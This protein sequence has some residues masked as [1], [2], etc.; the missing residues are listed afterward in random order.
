MSRDFFMKEADTVSGNNW[1]RRGQSCP[2]GRARP[3]YER[4]R[5]QM[6]RSC[7]KDSP[8]S[9]FLPV[10][11]RRHRAK[12]DAPRSEKKTKLDM[13]TPAKPT[14]EPISLSQKER[15]AGHRGGSP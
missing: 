9:S 14:R 1:R 5:S 4:R 2:E 11:T 6:S 7:E 8:I 13:E 3:H 15:A 12:S 10:A